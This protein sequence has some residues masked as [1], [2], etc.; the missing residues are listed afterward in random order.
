MTIFELKSIFRKALKMFIKIFPMLSATILLVGL[1]QSYISVEILKTLFGSNTFIDTFLATFLGSASVGQPFISY[2]IGGELLEQ[3]ISLFAIAAF[4]L[5]WVSIGFVQI[6][7]EISVFG[8]SFTLIR[9]ALAFIFTMF[10]AI[11]TTYTL[12]LLS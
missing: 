7:F 4:I 5:A 3:G 6:P 12:R 1:F 10:V 2:I 11:A 8:L 9:N